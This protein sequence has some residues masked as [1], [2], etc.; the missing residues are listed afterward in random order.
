MR[1]KA[2]A[3][4]TAEPAAWQY[5]TTDSTAGLQ[6]AGAVRLQT[7]LTSSATARRC[8]WDDLAVAPI[9]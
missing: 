8:R 2:W 6:A 1:A 3:A 5:T 9:G 4:G 7:Y